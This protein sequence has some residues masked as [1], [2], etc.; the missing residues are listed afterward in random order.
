MYI[1]LYCYAEHRILHVLTRP[2]PTRRSSDLS[3]P[4]QQALVARQVPQCG[5]CQSGMLMSASALL[6]ANSNPSDAEID[7]AMTGIC[8]CGTYPRL[9][10]AIR[11]IGRA[12]CRERVC[13]Y[14]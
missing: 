3:H 11:Q 14:V 2:V 7:A 12:P 1:F 4:V 10:T 8:R 6:R 13:Q 5:L 9:R